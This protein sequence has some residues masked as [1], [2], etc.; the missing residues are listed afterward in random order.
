M[1]QAVVFDFDGLIL[2]TETSDYLSWKAVYESFD[3]ELPLATWCENIG[4]T[5]FFN[6]Y[7]YLEGLLGRP[8]DRT[9]V[10]D[11]RKKLDLEMLDQL[12]ILPGVDNYLNE[13]RQLGLKVGIASSSDHKWVDGY[14]EKF[15][16][17]HRFDVVRCRDDVGDVGKPNPAVYLAAAAALGVAAPQAVALEDSPNGALAAR[18]AGMYCVAVPNQM[19]QALAFGEVHYRLQ[20]LADMPLAAL[21]EQ[22]RR[23]ETRD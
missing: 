20:S 23:L 3:C 5:D 19:T 10:H 6:P 8:I 21:L 11:Q 12:D 13:A 16:L 14:L 9:A 18:R 1:I 17:T 7:T 4:S 22:I 15:G 2:D